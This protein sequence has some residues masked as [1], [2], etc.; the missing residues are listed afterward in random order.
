MKAP[1]MLAVLVSLAGCGSPKLPPPLESPHPDP[2]TPAAPAPAPVEVEEPPARAPLTSFAGPVVAS[3]IREGGVLVFDV[4][5]GEG[6]AAELGDY[7]EVHYVL[8][9]DNGAAV[10][11]SHDRHKGLELVLGET[12]VIPGFAAGLIGI[13]RGMLRKIVVPPELGYRDREVANIPPNSTLT[14]YVE[15]IAVN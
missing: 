9:L 5:A 15:V 8:M 1:A 7:V 11:T 10:D 2:I 4:V 12:S 6:D 3:E 14:F 13:K